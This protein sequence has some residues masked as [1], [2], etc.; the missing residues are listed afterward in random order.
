MKPIDVGKRRNPSAYKPGGAKR[1]VLILIAVIV[2]VAVGVYG[3][4]R[5]RAGTSEASNTDTGLFTVKRGELAITVTESGG[6]KAVN[7]VD[8]KSEVEGQAS[9]V[10][11]VPEGSPHPSYLLHKVSVESHGF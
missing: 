1:I 8:L 9:I 5:Q 6:I 3:V 4:V 11:I 10:H 2:V 7:S